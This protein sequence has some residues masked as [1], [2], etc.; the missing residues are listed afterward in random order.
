MMSQAAS[1][2]SNARA[3]AA[4]RSGAPSPENESGDTLTIPMM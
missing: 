4:A 2:C 3:I 1:R